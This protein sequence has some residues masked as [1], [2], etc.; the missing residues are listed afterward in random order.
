MAE[1]GDGGRLGGKH[2]AITEIEGIAQGVA[3]GGARTIEGHCQRSSAAGGALGEAGN[4]RGVVA[5]LG[6]DRDGDHLRRGLAVRIGNGQGGVVGSLQT[7]SMS[8]TADG[9]GLGDYRGV[10]AEIKRVVGQGLGMNVGVDAGG[11]ERDR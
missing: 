10:V 9:G 6:R 5:A 7:V 2:G 11:I 3:A 1:V 4:G 8:D